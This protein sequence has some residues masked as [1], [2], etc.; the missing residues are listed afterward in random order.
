MHNYIKI[1]ISFSLFTLF[2]SCQ[3]NLVIKNDAKET[4]DSFINSNSKID[5]YNEYEIALLKI[6]AFYSSS[7]MGFHIVSVEN[8]KKQII[9]SKHYSYMSFKED[10][11]F[12][13]KFLGDRLCIS[14][15]ERIGR[16]VGPNLSTDYHKRVIDIFD[17]T[18]ITTITL[19][20]DIHHFSYGNERAAYSYYYDQNNSFSFTQSGYKISYSI[21]YWDETGRYPDEKFKTTVKPDYESKFNIT[22]DNYISVDFDT[23][24]Y[25]NKIIKNNFLCIYELP[26]GI[27]YKKIGYEKAQKQLQ[28]N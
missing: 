1:S 27:S 6:Y 7:L 5:F 21:K 23:E 16:C 19:F 25:L 15:Q 22:S 2:I 8:S 24:N 14:Y 3:S 20:G 9:Y 12:D 4:H 13:I 26:D 18:G 11:E 17:N 28:M 10:P